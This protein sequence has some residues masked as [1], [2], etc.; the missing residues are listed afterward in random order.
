M[1]RINIFLVLLVGICLQP[2]VLWADVPDLNGVWK[3]G[4]NDIQIVQTGN[5]VISEHKNQDIAAILGNNRFELEISG[6]LLKGRVATFLPNNKG[7]PDLSKKKF[8]GDNWATWSDI[9]L[10]LSADGNRLEGKWLSIK[11]DGN[12][13][14][15]PRSNVSSWVTYVLTRQIMPPPAPVA[16]S[17]PPPPAT[18]VVINNFNIEQPAPKEH[19][20]EDSCRDEEPGV[21]KRECK[22]M[23]EMERDIK[24]LKENVE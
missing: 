19:H 20:V 3:L 1:N 14:G 22:A 10:A 6:N 15:C 11:Q 12:K 17:A 2:T 5:K 23:R 16:V 8:C 9:T 21:R 24:K 18:P 7:Q 13:K 4:T